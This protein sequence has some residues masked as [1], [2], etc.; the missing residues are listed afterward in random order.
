MAHPREA[1]WSDD[2][3]LGGRI[4]ALQPRSGY[5]AGI[6]AVLLAAAVPAVGG[7]RVLEAGTGVGVVALCLASRV[8]N[9][10]VT[11]VEIQ[12]HL[13]EAARDNAA[14]NRLGHRVSVIQGDVCAGARGADATGLK[15]DTFDRVFANPPYFQAGKV[16]L[17]P[18]PA[19]ARS[20]AADEQDLDR[21]MRFMV[22]MVRPSGTMTLI[23]TADAL[24][25]LLAACDNRFGGLHVVP[26]HPRRGET[27]NRV[28]LHGVKAS[29]APLKLLHSVALHR[30]DGSYEEEIED[31]LRRGKALGW[32]ETNASCGGR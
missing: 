11:G 12:P 7:E 9:L 18:D 16:R 32:F 17:P 6:D 20:H 13:C 25:R 5:R 15:P 27:A 21:W 19:R 28:L 10:T 14:R 29:R 31:A 4:Q 3:F 1:D 26:L 24:P 8:E 22:S 30:A 2:A 23:H